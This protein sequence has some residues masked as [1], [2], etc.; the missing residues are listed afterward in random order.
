MFF[1]ITVTVLLSLALRYNLPITYIASQ[2]YSSL[3]VHF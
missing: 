1:N 2:G 3:Y